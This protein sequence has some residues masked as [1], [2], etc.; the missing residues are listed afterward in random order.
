V[1]GKHAWS[2]SHA[3]LS[4]QEGG[5]LSKRHAHGSVSQLRVRHPLVLLFGRRVRCKVLPWANSLFFLGR[6]LPELCHY[7]LSRYYFTMAYWRAFTRTDPNNH[8]HSGV[9]GARRQAG[10]PH[11]FCC[12]GSVILLYAI[13]SRPSCV[14]TMSLVELEELVRFQGPLSFL[15]CSRASC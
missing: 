13:F 6:R 12:C 11:P 1:G 10:T 2:T 14:Q 4:L 15:S 7:Q 8:R 3:L 9:G 5:K